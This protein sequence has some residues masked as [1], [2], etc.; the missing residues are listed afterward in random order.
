MVY[1]VK[2]VMLNENVELVYNIQEG[3]TRQNNNRNGGYQRDKYYYI[4]YT[5]EDKQQMKNFR[6]NKEENS[7]VK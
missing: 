5:K 6:M 1:M 2:K 4:K 3:Y 7:D